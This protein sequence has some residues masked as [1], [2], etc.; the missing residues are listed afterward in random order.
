MRGG[1][2]SRDIDFGKSE[3]EMFFATGLDRG[4]PFEA[5]S[6]ISFLAHLVLAAI[7]Y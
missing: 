4:D 6:K 5:A 7:G 3:I 2:A 1:T